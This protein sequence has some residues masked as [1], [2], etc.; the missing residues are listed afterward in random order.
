MSLTI[1]HASAAAWQDEAHVRDN[2]ARYREKF[3]C[4]IIVAHQ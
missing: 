2:R 1:Q 3:A 4:I